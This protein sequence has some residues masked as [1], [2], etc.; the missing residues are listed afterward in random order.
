MT[1]RRT[2][3]VAQLPEM[4]LAYFEET[5]PTEGLD[6]GE[7]EG[8]LWD[9][10]NAWREETRPELGRIDIA[11]VAFAIR[12]EGGETVRLRAAVPI[13][14]DYSP[15]EPAR[16]TFFPGGL[17]A[18][19]YAD[20]V[21]EIELAFEAVAEWLPGHGYVPSGPALEVFKFHYN[22]DQHPCDCGFIVE[23][24]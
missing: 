14:S 11:A 24:E 8:A 12:E 21:D 17:F 22:L 2:V 10:F 7:A 4:R 16:T 23:R 6:F 18:Y 1:L 15:A 3:R 9:R 20:N 13:R 19:A 5:H